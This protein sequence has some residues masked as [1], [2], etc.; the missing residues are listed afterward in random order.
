VGITP[1]DATDQYLLWS[2][3]NSDV[4]AIDAQGQLHALAVGSAVIRVTNPLTSLHAETE[5]KVTPND[6]TAPVSVATVS[7][8]AH[9][10]SY[11]WYTS[12]VTVSMSVYDHLSGVAKTEYQVNNG[13]WITY[14][15]SIPAF[16]EGIYKVDYHST[17]QAGNVEQ[18]QTIE[19]KIDKTAPLLTV[20]LD[21]TSIWS[22]NHK[23][24]VINPALHSSDATSGVESVVLT[25]ITSNEPD[26]G[27]GDIEANIGTAATS[28]RLRADRLGNGSGR[29]YTITYTVT[30]KAGNKTDTSVTV[31][32][33]HDQST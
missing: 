7:P 28:F 20:Q 12:D 23:M 16:G 6:K 24:V 29:I 1:N 11:G 5:V 8:T 9:N 31:T 33:P 18:I 27:Q 30:D 21:K 3:T 13:G 14:T 22:A 10:G 25:S 19:F 17:D 26:S 4:A 32:V 15:G 2:S